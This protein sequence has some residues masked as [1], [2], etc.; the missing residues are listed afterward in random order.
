MNDGEGAAEKRVSGKVYACPD[1]LRG[2]VA[3]KEALTLVYSDDIAE[4]EGF[5]IF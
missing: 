1:D 5:V 3:L 2:A 4:E